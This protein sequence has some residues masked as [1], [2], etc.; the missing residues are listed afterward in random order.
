MKIITVITFLIF[1]VITNAQ[2]VDNGLD[3]V[4]LKSGTNQIKP[5]SQKGNKNIGNWWASGTLNLV[6]GAAEY[7]ANKG[8]QLRQKVAL[9]EGVAYTISFD[10]WIVDALEDD[11]KPILVFFV[12]DPGDVNIDSSTSE[13]GM[14]VDQVGA[15]DATS[16]KCK[17]DITNTA[18]ESYTTIFT[19]TSTD[20][21]IICLQRNGSNGNKSDLLYVDN[22]YMSSA[23]ASDNN[24]IAQEINV[25]PNPANTIIHIEANSS[26]QK[27]RLI[28][29]LGVTVK[30]KSIQ[31]NFGALDVF[32]LP[33]GLYVLNV[34]SENG[35]HTRKILVD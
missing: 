20:N 4:D 7:P 13:L 3:S 19:P 16:K 29:S 2:L 10:A 11:T 14:S 9:T 26:I 15:I 5:N 17:I 28:N 27:L 24:N 18:S 34:Q 33:S 35:N 8:P 21:F 25:F 23:T 12:K 31:S 6:N 1:S 32:D 22:I 30:Q